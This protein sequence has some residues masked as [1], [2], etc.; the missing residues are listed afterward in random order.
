MKKI[1]SCLLVGTLV[2][3]GLAHYAVSAHKNLSSAKTVSLKKMTLAPKKKKSQARVY[4]KAVRAQARSFKPNKK[5][6]DTE[7]VIALNGV[8]ADAPLSQQLA[9]KKVR[10]SESK[11]E[12]NRADMDQAQLQRE[13]KDALALAD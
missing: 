7:I 4:Q 10:K 5:S 12:A 2:I 8:D 13:L 1:V 3:V 6:I 9:W 11:L